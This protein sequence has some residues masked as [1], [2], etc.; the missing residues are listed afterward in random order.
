[1]GM[2]FILLGSTGL[3]ISQA[4]EVGV[5]DLLNLENYANQETPGYITRDN[6][7]AGNP[8]TDLG[9]TLGRVL[10]YDKRLSRNDT[11]S[12]A[13]C[14]H[15]EHAFSDVADASAGVNGST[16]R[17]SMRLINNRYSQDRRRFW[18]E[19]ANSVE[20]QSTQPIQD[21][22]EMGFSGAD[23][24]PDFS[25]LV[26]KLSAI[27]EYQVMFVGVFGD[28]TITET[29]IQRALAQFIRSIQ[30]FDSKYDEGRSQVD[31]DNVNF[32][33]FTADENAGKALF[34]NP[35]TPPRPGRQVAGAD[36]VLSALVDAPDSIPGMFF[37]V[38]YFGHEGM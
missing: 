32:P 10:F 5:I 35:P 30:S 8:I 26:S 16:G 22:I 34:L 6:T 29:R 23:G 18:D 36:G 13:S 14:H 9:A 12:C 17:H 15:Q 20:A 21:H 3:N 31:N 7:P 2:S 37:R 1:M 24:D 11:I 38:S 4:T 27:E 28:P 25:D 19:R 33:N